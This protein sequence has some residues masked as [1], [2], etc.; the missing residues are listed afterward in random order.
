MKE[1]NAGG[2]VSA[3]L[4][5]LGIR[6][7]IMEGQ[8]PEEE[9]SFLRIDEK[10]EATLIPASDYKAMRTYGLVE[11]ILET[12]GEKTSVLCIGPAGDYRLASA[13]IQSSDID[14]RPCRAAGRGG[15]G[16]VMGAKGLKT[17]IVDQR[18]QSPD[19][20]ADPEAF[21]AAA[22]VVAKTIKEDPM[23]GAG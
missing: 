12:Y 7:V 2:T 4:G 22:K 15:L 17:L 5:R 3:A 16:A 6:A 19:P 21:E 10:G 11:E 13:S 1:S 23:S 8:A 14:G 9:M 20:I 18:G